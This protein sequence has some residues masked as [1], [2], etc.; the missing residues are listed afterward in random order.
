MS[1][2][3]LDLATIFTPIRVQVSS[4]L[5]AKLRK[6]GLINHTVRGF[7]PNRGGVSLFVRSTAPANTVPSII[8]IVNKLYPNL[9][10]DYYSDCD[11]IDITC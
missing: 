11:I 4:R 8:A 2:T 10:V 7:G 5:N 6:A 3:A 1:I 9:S